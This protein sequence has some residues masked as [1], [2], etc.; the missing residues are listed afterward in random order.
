MLFIVIFITSLHC[1]IMT[2][3]HQTDFFPALRSTLLTSRW[4]LLLTSATVLHSVIFD[5]LIIHQSL[6]ISLLLLYITCDIAIITYYMAV[7]VDFAISFLKYLF[8]R[9]SNFTTYERLVGHFR[10]ANVKSPFTEYE[11]TY[12]LTTC[13][14]H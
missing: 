14:Y 4:L 10:S 3:Y 1:A 2:I 7:L 11:R 13:A 8:L 5:P 9:I 6:F 12:S